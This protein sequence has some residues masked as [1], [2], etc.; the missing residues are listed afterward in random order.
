LC[1]PEE[2]NTIAAA[3]GRALDD[4]ALPA[5]LGERG[6]RYAAPY[7]WRAAATS[8]LKIYRSLL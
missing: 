7:T 3:I 2:A 4:D 6:R 1:E 8:M 5:D